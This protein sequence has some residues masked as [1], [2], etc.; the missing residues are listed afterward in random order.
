MPETEGLFRKIDTAKTYPRIL[1]VGL[2]LDAL[3]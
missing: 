1:A 3:D 2:D